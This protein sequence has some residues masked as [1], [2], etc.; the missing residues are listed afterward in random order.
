M[1]FRR[2]KKNDTIKEEKKAINYSFIDRDLD[3][4]IAYT[5]VISGID[6]EPKKTV[7][8]KK[9]SI[10]CQNKEL[11]SFKTL[12]RGI[13][14]DQ[15]LAQ[16]FLN[17]ITVNETYF[18]R[19]LPQ[20]N[21][22]VRFIKEQRRK[23]RVLCA[24]CST[25]EEVYSLAS[26]AQLDNI[27]QSEIEIIGIDINSQAIQSAKEACFSARSLHRLEQ[28]TIDLFFN[29]TDTSFVI[30][31]EKFSNI[32]FKVVNIFDNEFSKLGKFDIIFSRN[33]MIYFNDDFKQKCIKLFYN[34]LNT[35]GRLYTGHADLVPENPYFNKV[36]CS[37]TYYY[38]KK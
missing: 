21:E 6:L 18:Y 12:L 9:I 11:E 15:A 32:D 8:S 13:K 5:K 31:K 10:F 36:V 2:K 16:D 33:M 22:A 4:L 17:L 14:S 23:M 35:N 26:L 37:S 19:E 38:E 28:N 24:P 20:L 30:K 29:K 3:E 25:G 1:F 27:N 7:L 34:S